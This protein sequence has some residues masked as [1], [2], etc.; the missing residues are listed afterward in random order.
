[1]KLMS[2]SGP[3]C[4]IMIEVISRSFPRVLMNT[5]RRACE[6]RGQAKPSIIISAE[7]QKTFENLVNQILNVEHIP[8]EPLAFCMRRCTC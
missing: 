6:F 5:R 2:R 3:T 1:M 7:L 8:L 4:S